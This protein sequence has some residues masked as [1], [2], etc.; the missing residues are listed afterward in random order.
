MQKKTKTWKVLLK[1]NKNTEN[2]RTWRTN[3]EHQE[4]AQ[5]HKSRSRPNMSKLKI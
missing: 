3:K 4:H 5:Q 2:S 1:T